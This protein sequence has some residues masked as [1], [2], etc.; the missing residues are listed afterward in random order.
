M[1]EAQRSGKN[2]IDYF[3]KLFE[4][5]YIFSSLKYLD[6]INLINGQ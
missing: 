6:V 4:G 2:E 5:Q 1:C 3:G